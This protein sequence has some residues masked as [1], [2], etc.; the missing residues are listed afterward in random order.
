[1]KIRDL[2]VVVVLRGHVPEIVLV[3]AREKEH[4]QGFDEMK[5]RRRLPR[6]T[7]KR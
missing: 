5:G 6:I 2:D 1:M 7:A 3:F 4:N